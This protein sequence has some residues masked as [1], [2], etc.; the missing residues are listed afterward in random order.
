MRMLGGCVVSMGLALGDSGV[1]AI[2][3]GCVSYC[4][5]VPY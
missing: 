4:E 5:F 3:A 1:K 2:L